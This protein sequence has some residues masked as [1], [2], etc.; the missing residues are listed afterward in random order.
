MIISTTTLIF[1]I[2]YSRGKEIHSSLDQ[3]LP[4]P[5]QQQQMQIALE[6]F[7]KKS[8]EIIYPNILETI[9]P[10]TVLAQIRDMSKSEGNLDFKPGGII[11]DDGGRYLYA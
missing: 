7:W 6:Q 11:Y 10:E 1:T 5:L 2:L 3:I 4:E 9:L 8:G